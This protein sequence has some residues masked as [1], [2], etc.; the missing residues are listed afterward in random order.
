MMTKKTHKNR[1]F[2]VITGDIIASTNLPF[3]SRDKLYQVMIQTSR[4]IE[5]KFIA[6][7]PMGVEIFSGDSWQM[8]LSNPIKALRLSLFYRAMLRA[9]M[10]SHRI[11]TKIA[12]AIGEIDSIPDNR[13]IEGY[14]EAFEL[15]GRA[16]EKMP[17]ASNMCF[18][19]PDKKI[20]NILNT[21]IQLIDTI[22]SKWSDKQALAITG[23]LQGWKQEKIAKTLWEKEISQQAIAQ[24]LSSA[25][26]H[27]VEKGILFFEQL[28]EESINQNK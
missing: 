15:S 17:K 28:L 24:H 4:S 25:G 12:I 1:L 13:V 26:W 9:K 19:F 27:S 3:N 10:E 5:E 23:A 18:V 2:A 16:L 20:E 8:I 7:L 22:S 6:Y 11:D 21:V 14:G